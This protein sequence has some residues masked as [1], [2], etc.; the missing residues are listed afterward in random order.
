MVEEKF[1]KSPQPNN[2]NQAIQQSSLFN[3]GI[4]G[5]TTL[6][7]KRIDLNGLY[8]LHAISQGRALPTDNIKIKAWLQTLQRKKYVTDRGTITLK[9]K[10]LLNEVATGTKEVPVVYEK[11]DDP[12]EKW[13]KEA[14]P[15]TDHFEYNGQVFTGTQAK[16][17]DKEECRKLYWEIVNEGEYTTEDI[18]WGTLCLV[19]NAKKKSLQTGQSEIHYI[20]NSKRFLQLKKFVPFVKAGRSRFTGAQQDHSTLSSNRYNFD[21]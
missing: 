16:H 14:Y 13:W 10:S 5:L 8:L 19:E 6:L 7:E 4:A 9:G 17:E 18:F 11:K 15:D 20:P 3:I 12:F 2:G 21:I 1:Q